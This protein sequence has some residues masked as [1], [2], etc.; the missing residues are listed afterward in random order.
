MVCVFCGNETQVT[1]SRHQRRNNNVW[2]RRR[3]G[4]CH[5]VF[6]TIESVDYASALRVNVNGDFKPFLSDLLYT[7]VLLTLSH[8]KMAYMDAREVT[9]TI[10]KNL[11][12]LP[13]HPLFLPTDI[14][15]VTA[16]VLQ[17]FDKRAWHRY[18]AEH[19]S[20]SD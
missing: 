4:A 14:S 20:V 19:P 1:N 3:C 9:N 2:R 10:I 7:E 18:A 16:Q 8:R 11:L 15:R 13:S 5:S 12:G 17:K 6:T